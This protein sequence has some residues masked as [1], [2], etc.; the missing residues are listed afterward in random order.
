VPKEHRVFRIA[1]HTILKDPGTAGL[2]PIT[3]NMLEELRGCANDSLIFVT[4]AMES[5]Y[6]VETTNVRP[7]RCD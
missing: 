5:M 7:G 1:I 2:E 6:T 4:A 3:S